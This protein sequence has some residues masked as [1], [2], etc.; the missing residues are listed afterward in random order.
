MADEDQSRESESTHERNKK[1]KRSPMASPRPSTMT[2]RSRFK[3]RK[4]N[5]EESGSVEGSSYFRYEIIEKKGG[6]F[7]VPV[8]YSVRH[9]EGCAD[10]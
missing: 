3:K 2:L 9:Q 5:E 8:R 10:P 6:K 7:L 4:L 1:R